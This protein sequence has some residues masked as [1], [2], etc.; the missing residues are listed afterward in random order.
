M[1]AQFKLSLTKLTE[2]TGGTQEISRDDVSNDKIII[3]HKT[4]YLKAEI[5]F[6]CS[7]KEEHVIRSL[8]TCLIGKFGEESF[9][10]NGNVRSENILLE[11]LNNFTR[12][13]KNTY[14]PKLNFE[15]Q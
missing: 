7:E 3:N 8:V 6:D 1:K 11:D 5:K 10:I 9:D 13:I 4:Q 12:Y 2:F 15:R 14:S